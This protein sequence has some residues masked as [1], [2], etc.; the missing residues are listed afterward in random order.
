MLGFC[1]LAHKADV[2]K[3]ILPELNLGVFISPTSVQ[4]EPS[5]CSVV[6]GAPE[7]DNAAVDVPTPPPISDLAVFKSPTSV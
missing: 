3:P 6:A 1:P 7:A 2:Y 4:E 5:H